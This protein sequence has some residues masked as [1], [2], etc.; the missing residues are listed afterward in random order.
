MQGEKLE[1]FLFRIYRRC[2]HFKRPYRNGFLFLV[3]RRPKNT[4]QDIHFVNLNINL[5]FSYYKLG[6]RSFE[7]NLLSHCFNLKDLNKH[8]E[9][10]RKDLL[11]VLQLTDV[12]K[13]PKCML[14][15]FQ[16]QIIYT[17][18]KALHSKPN[19]NCT[20]RRKCGVT[21]AIN[22]S[23]KYIDDYY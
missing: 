6:C 17:K 16:D 3:F 9:R 19:G 11:F 10:L 23:E 12:T 21:S 5:L 7:F 1:E 13:C 8:I 22:C 2:L 18:S 4:A 15:T 20:A 14:F